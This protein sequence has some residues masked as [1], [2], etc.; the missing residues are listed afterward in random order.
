MSAH[1]KQR[2]RVDEVVRCAWPQGAED[3]AVNARFARWDALERAG[4]V[5]GIGGLGCDGRVALVAADEHSSAVGGGSCGGVG[6]K[7]R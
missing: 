5:V 3:V 6:R 1:R 4:L 2:R 7:A